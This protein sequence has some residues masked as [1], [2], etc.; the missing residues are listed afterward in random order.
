MRLYERSPVFL[1]R[2]EPDPLEETV[3]NALVDVMTN[4]VMPP[5]EFNQ[6]IERL[7]KLLEIVQV[8]KTHSRVSKDTLAI[9]GANLFGILMIIRHEFANPLNS[10][11]L[12]LLLRPRI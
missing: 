2:R 12:S 11:A 1:R 8:D 6:K 5:E 9:I 7:S 3:R 10:K 4:P